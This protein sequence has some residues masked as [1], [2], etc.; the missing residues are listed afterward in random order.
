MTLTPVDT[1]YRPTAVVEINTSASATS[2][3]LV[4]GYVSIPQGRLLINNPNGDDVQITGG[5]LA[6]QFDVTDS[7]ANGA[8]SVPLGFVAAIVQRVL[9]IVS[10]T[11]A[12][13][14]SSI[15]VVQV[16]QNG[17]YAVNS[18]QVQ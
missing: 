17:A 9:R 10:T 14:E 16:N 6:A 2:H 4:P 15:A 11:S 1:T 13:K 3:V 18:W 5:I 12:G 7:R 8:Q